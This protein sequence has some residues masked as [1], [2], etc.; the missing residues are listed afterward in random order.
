MLEQDIILEIIYLLQIQEQMVIMQFGFVKIVNGGFSG[1]DNTTGMSTGDRIV[2][3]D[4]TTRGDSYS[5]DVIVQEKFTDLQQITDFFISNKGSGYT[6]LPT[7]SVT[8]S[9]GTN[10]N[11]KGY[12]DEVGKVVKVKTVELGRGYENSPTP[13][14]LTFFNNVIVTNISGTF[15]ATQSVTSSS[16]GSGTI[17][18]LDSDRGLL[19]IKDVTGNFNVDDTLT[20][21]LQVLVLLKNQMLQL[22]Q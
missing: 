20:S 11:I 1:E 19:K 15:I 17:V 8:S 16:G 22:L 9:T 12:G 3:E 14:T 2:L 7:V 6:T 5:G 21:A 18:S 13:P 10:A 4:E